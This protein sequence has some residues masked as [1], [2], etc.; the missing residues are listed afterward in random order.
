MTTV[1]M[2]GNNNNGNILAEN[3]KISEDFIG[4]VSKMFE[5]IDEV[6]EK[7]GDGAYL[8]LANQFKSLMEFKDKMTTNVV[9]I[10]HERRTRMRVMENKRKKTLAEKLADKKKYVKCWKCDTVITKKELSEHQQRRKCR[11][12]HSSRMITLATK[13][14]VLKEGLI[15]IEDTLHERTGHYWIN[16]NKGEK[17]FTVRDYYENQI[18]H[19]NQSATKI[20]ALYRGYK[21]RKNMKKEKKEKKDLPTITEMLKEYEEAYYDIDSIEVPTM[22]KLKKR[23]GAE[24]VKEKLD[25]LKEISQNYNEQVKS[26][27]SRFR[28]YTDII[29]NEGTDEEKSQLVSYIGYIN[30]AQRRKIGIINRRR[31]AIIHL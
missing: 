16:E 24:A 2:S 23:F 5:T 31:K 20:Q 8:E 30:D 7:I 14:K 3:K 11:H 6:S 18:K 26:I 29:R 1:N 4:L 28:E 9:Y 10:E 25:Y 12:I 13:T 21:V 27:Q 15:I 17:I 22:A 19:E